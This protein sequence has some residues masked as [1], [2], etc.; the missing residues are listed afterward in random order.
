MVALM[1]PIFWRGY[2]SWVS[3]AD[4]LSQAVLV[5]LLIGVGFPQ[6]ASVIGFLG[7]YGPDAALGLCANFAR[8]SSMI[9]ISDRRRI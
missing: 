5:G 7:G 2:L 4:F 3:R 9:V 1:A 6:V 8:R